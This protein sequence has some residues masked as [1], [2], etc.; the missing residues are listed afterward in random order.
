MALLTHCADGDLDPDRL[1]K[2]L[3][4]LETGRHDRSLDFTD[5]YFH[6]P[7]ELAEELVCAGF[8]DVRVLGIEGPAWTAVDAAGPDSEAHMN[9]ALLCARAV[10]ED[11]ALL[12]ASAHL[13]AV[14]RGPSRSGGAV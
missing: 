14:G 5:A 2:L 12:P 3:P 1:T 10:E 13:L 9:A 8:E 4:T 7:Q 6:R 11:R